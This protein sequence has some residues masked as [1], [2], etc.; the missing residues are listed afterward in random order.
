MSALFHHAC[1]LP[2]AVFPQ[3]ALPLWERL[4]EDQ[5][6]IF[7]REQQEEQCCSLRVPELLSDI[8]IHWDCSGLS[9]LYYD[10]STPF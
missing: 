2:P 5:F 7:I 4:E 9:F 8:P 3:E 10:T 6:C 1:L